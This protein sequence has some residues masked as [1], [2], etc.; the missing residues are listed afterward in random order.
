MKMFGVADLIIGMTLVFLSSF[1]PSA[2][3]LISFSIIAFT[4]SSLGM[5][6]DFGSWIDF[7]A[8][9]LLGIAILINIPL[10]LSLVVGFLVLQKG[11][12]SFF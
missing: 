2:N 9:I 6:R 12:F 5:L 10:F 4:K 11:I 8:G 3:I 1:N 7:S